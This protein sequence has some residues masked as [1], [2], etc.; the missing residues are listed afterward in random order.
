[1]KDQSK[2]RAVA[3]VLGVKYHHNANDATVQAAIDSHVAAQSKKEPELTM[4]ERL[5]AADPADWKPLTQAEY[6]KSSSTVA[7]RRKESSRLIRVR[8]QNM[9]PAK[10]DWPGEI[11][12]VG[13][14]KLGTYKKYVPFNSPEPYHVPKIIYD[15]MV[16]KKC[17]I[18]HTE[19]DRRGDD[20][21]KGRLVN[22]YA[23]EV[24]PPL[25]PEELSALAQRQALQAGQQ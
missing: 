6:R 25:T 5:K 20:V 9:N 1:M 2:T 18:F 3:D 24:M 13:S 14:A 15:M 4:H 19:K 17:T 10:K 7:D 12:S 8:I 16:E 22:E 11:L 23:L 21:R